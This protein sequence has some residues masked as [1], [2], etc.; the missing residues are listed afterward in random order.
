MQIFT[1]IAAVALALLL[2]GSC[3]RNPEKYCDTKGIV[4]N[5]IVSGDTAPR[6]LVGLQTPDF[7]I[8]AIDGKEFLFSEIRDTDK[9]TVLNFWATWCKPCKGNLDDIAEL[10]KKYGDLDLDI[11]SI[12][13][14]DSSE[15]WRSA[16]ASGRYP[17][18]H[19]IDSGN[20]AFQKFYGR[21]IPMN[22][23][24]DGTGKIVAID[25]RGGALR[26]AIGACLKRK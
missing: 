3:G 19:F 6:T 9:T 15:E 24:I 25:V 11:I 10:E 17:W 21:Y 4:G 20:E 1:H 8:T 22:V 5:E 16:L 26:S 7:R 13:C 12:S 23:I 2:C 18:R 14:D